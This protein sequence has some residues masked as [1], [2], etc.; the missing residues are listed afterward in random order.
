M[1]IMEKKNVKFRRIS[2][3]SLIHHTMR[4]KVSEHLCPNY[5]EFFSVFSEILP[6]FLTNQNFWGGACTPL[7]PGVEI[8]YRDSITVIHG[9]NCGT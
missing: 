2:T 6:G 3:A 9:I 8:T 4:T 7:H 5:A 1:C